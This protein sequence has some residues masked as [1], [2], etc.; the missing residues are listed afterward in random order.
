MEGEVTS[1]LMECLFGNTEFHSLFISSSLMFWNP[2]QISRKLSPNIHSNIPKFPMN[3]I[4][5]TKKITEYFCVNEKRE[6]S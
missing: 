6:E 5:K 2:K 3:F 1:T 4:I